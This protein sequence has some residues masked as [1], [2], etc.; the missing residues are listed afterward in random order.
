MYKM[1][2][3]HY[4]QHIYELQPEKMVISFHYEGVLSSL[5]CFYSLFRQLSCKTE[6]MH[7]TA[8]TLRNLEI[9][10]NQVKAHF[11]YTKLVWPN[12]GSKTK[13]ATVDFCSEGDQ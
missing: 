10:T 3:K 12:K 9:L 11:V 2:M 5:F 1:K 8:A 6:G 4:M 7:L 13:T